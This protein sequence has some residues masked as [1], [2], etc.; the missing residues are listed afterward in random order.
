[1]SSLNFILAYVENAPRSAELYGKV[2]GLEPVESSPNFAMFALPNH[3]MFGLWSRH[4]VVPAANKPGGVE[5]AFTVE[6]AAVLNAALA[7]WKALGLTIIQE[8]TEMDFGLTFTATDP[9]GHRL[10]AFTPS[11]TAVHSQQEMSRH[12]AAH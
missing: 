12:H 8:P 11:E 7:E 5:L 1:M 4:D 2:L 9:D 3:V 6:N 10:R